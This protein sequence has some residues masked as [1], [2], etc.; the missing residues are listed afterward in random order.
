MPWLLGVVLCVSSVASAPVR[1]QDSADVQVSITRGDAVKI[2]GVDNWTIGVYGPDD[3]LPTNFQNAWDLIC[4]YSSTGVFGLELV[5]QN[6]AG[7]FTAKSGGD[8]L[9]YFV[10]VVYYQGGLNRLQVRRSNENTS[11]GTV[12]NLRGSPSLT[13]ADDEFN[14]GNNLGLAAF[15]RKADFDAAPPGIYQDVVTVIVR[16]E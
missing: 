6:G 4:V 7:P 13:C 2:S 11:P 1:S 12:S 5:S 8:E 10:Q 3:T 15:M 9:N 14:G 16:P